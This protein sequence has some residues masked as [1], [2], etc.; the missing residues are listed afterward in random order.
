MNRKAFTLI[1]LLVVIAIIA[2]LA[3]ILFPVF[4]KAREKARQVACSSNERQIGLGILQYVQDYDELFP[5][6]GYIPMFSFPMAGNDWTSQIAPYVK[7][8]ESFTVHHRKLNHV[9][10]GMN[11]F[12]GC[13]IGKG[14]V[15]AGA[16]DCGYG[17]GLFGRRMVASRAR[18]C[19]IKSSAANKHLDGFRSAQHSL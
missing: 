13:G 17:Q 4:S 1:E 9:D 2:I 12:L 7:S 6:Y 3:A 8:T 16:T 18:S 5:G 19:R 11:A 14:Q 10:Y 15:Q